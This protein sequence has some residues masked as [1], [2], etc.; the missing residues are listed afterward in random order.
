MALQDENKKLKNQIEQIEGTWMRK[1]QAS[2]Q[3]S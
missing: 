1:Y 2:S 3:E